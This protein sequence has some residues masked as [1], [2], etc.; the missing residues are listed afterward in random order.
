MTFR[1]TY[2]YKGMCE[3]IPL[4]NPVRFEDLS[5]DELVK[6]SSS[7]SY[8]PTQRALAS[9][10]FQASLKTDCS[11]EALEEDGKIILDLEEQIPEWIK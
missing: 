10:I 1:I 9:A 6:I 2:Y 8:H 11:I 7:S 3:I 5:P 4:F